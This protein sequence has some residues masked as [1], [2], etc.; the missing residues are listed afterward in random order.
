MR[1]E[2]PRAA[3]YPFRATLALTTLD[4]S[5]TSRQ[6]TEDLSL[7]GCYIVPGMSPPTGTRVRIQIIYKGEVCEA[8]GRVTDVRK[9]AC[10][11]IAFTQVE[12]GHQL[13]LDKWIAEIRN[14]EAESLLPGD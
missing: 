3:R 12:Q 10:A 4:T 7:F 8:L 2:R 5:H 9:D 6:C 13:I 11:G 1:V 14:T